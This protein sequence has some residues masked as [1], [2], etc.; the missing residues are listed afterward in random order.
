MRGGLSFLSRCDKSHAMKITRVLLIVL[1][2]GAVGACSGGGGSSPPPPTAQWEKFRHDVNNSGAGNP[3]LGDNNGVIMWQTQID[4]TPISASPAIG[5]PLPGGDVNG[6]LYIATE[7]GTLAALAPTTGEINWTICSCDAPGVPL[8]C[9]A[10]RASTLGPLISSPAVYTFIS[11]TNI[12]IGSANGAVYMFQD[13]GTTRTCAARFEPAAADFG[14]STI[15]SRFISSPGFTINPSTSAVSSVFIGAAV[16]VTQNGTTRT[17]GK[18]YALNTNGTPIWQYPPLGAAEEI[19]AITSS[20]VLGAV[21]TVFFTT[22][23][24]YVYGLTASGTFKWRFFIGATTDPDAPFSPSPLTTGQIFAPSTSGRIFSLNPDGSFHWSVPPL[25]KPE[26]ES[27]FLS[28]LAVGLPATTITPTVPPTPTPPP[29]AT[30]AP[31]ETPT[32]VRLMTAIF[33]VTGAGN[34]VQIDL[35]TGMINMLQNPAEKIAGPVVSSPMLSADGYL[36]VG[37][38]DGTLHAINTITGLPPPLQPPPPTPPT[39]T[40][41]PVTLAAGV[42]IRSSPS[43]SSVDNNGIVN[44]IVYVGADNGKVYAV[45][46]GTIPTPT[47]TR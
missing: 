3:S 15:T 4:M 38:A 42:P 36:V 27:G 12:F 8:I 19:G 7:G 46:P 39:P 17:I 1:P 16:D 37:A 23:D 25:D 32:P 45:G 24:G 44:G 6:E 35:I 14:G 40:G 28:S 31:T 10:G 30:A 9:P 43:A 18:L 21:D 13:N 34:L 2:L 41:W 47:V 11:T 26:F 33:G 20:P 29:G 5:L 22:E